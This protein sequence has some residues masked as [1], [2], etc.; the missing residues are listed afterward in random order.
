MKELSMDIKA[1]QNKL[2]KFAEE[3]DWNQF[4]SPKNLSSALVCE[5]AELVEI[6]QWMTESD[7]E[8]LTD[9]D[10]KK[11]ISHEIA[12]IQLYL[13][14]IADRLNIDIENAVQEKLAINAEKYPIS[15]SKGNST[16]YSRRKS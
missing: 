12:D 6:F 11:E 16:K 15:L 2:Q 3:R 14:R 10:L 8:N 9:D 1:Y 13:M 5:A 7:S 4:H